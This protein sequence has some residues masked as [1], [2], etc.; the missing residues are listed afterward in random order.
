MTSL[1]KILELKPSKIYPGHGPDIAD[2]V[3]KIKAYIDHRLQRE[4]QILAVLK[5]D[6]ALSPMQIV[7]IVYMVNYNCFNFF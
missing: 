4:Q 7:K 1:N 5:K 2:P 3:P 6:E